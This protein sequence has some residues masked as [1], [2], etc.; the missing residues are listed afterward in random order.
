MRN[1]LLAF[2]IL[3]SVPAEAAS[4][5]VFTEISGDCRLL[6]GDRLLAA[7]E[8]VE[9]DEDDIVETASA[10]SAQLEMNDGSVLKLGANSRVLLAEYHLDTDRNVVKAGIDVLTGW[11]RFAVAKLRRPDSRFGINTPTMTIGIRGTEG[12][13]EASNER[14]ALLLE[15]GQVAVHAADAGSMPVRAGEFVQRARGSAFNRP[16]GVPDEFRRHLPGTLRSRVVRRTHQLSRRG[17]A[18]RE[19][20]RLQPADR[21]RL[22]REHPF[23]RQQLDRRFRGRASGPVRVPVAPGVTQGSKLHPAAHPGHAK[24]GA[25]QR[26][27]R[28]HSR[29]KLRHRSP[30]PHEELKKHREQESRVPAEWKGRAGELG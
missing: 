27:G 29:A 23:R 16:Q 5:G 28:S 24:P 15:S 21:E 11:I 7:A 9:V 3:L 6:R 13:I 4:V 8:G 1:L 22:L 19:I 10:A 25:E 12:V 14:G 2:W 18:A 26:P 20:R 30:R 17:V